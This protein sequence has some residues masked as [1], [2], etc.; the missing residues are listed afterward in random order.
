MQGVDTA[1]YFVHAIGT[2]GDFETRTGRP[3]QLRWPRDQRALGGS[4]TWAVS[5]IPT[6][7]FPSICAA[8][9]KRAI[10]SVAPPAG[11]RVPG[12][13]RDRLG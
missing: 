8:A 9:R 4:S 2:I 11:P 7:R 12:L 1:Y 13:D 6:K 5:A 3:R 10:C